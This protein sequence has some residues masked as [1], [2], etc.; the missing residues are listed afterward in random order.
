MIS[1][2]WIQCQTLFGYADTGIVKKERK[3]V[4]VTCEAKNCLKFFLQAIIWLKNGESDD[5][6]PK[7]T[8]VV[9]RYTIE[10]IV[11]MMP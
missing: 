3:T 9:A 7:V 1:E 10:N 8:I 11:L 5:S 4:G 2:V 6:S